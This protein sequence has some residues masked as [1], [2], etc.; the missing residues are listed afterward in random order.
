[1]Q[2]NPEC[3]ILIYAC[4]SQVTKMKITTLNRLS[5]YGTEQ[6]TSLSAASQR[7]GHFFLHFA[8]HFFHCLIVILSDLILSLMSVSFVQRV[9]LFVHKEPYSV[10]GIFICVNH[11]REEQPVCGWNH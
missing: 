2:H 1:M 7:Y 11:N 4:C 8:Q 10:V 9:L 5:I 6:N 3:C